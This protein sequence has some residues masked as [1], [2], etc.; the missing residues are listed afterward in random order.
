M[1]KEN[2]VC[3]VCHSYT[4][5]LFRSKVLEKYTV[6]YYKCLSCE[7]IQTEKQYWTKEAYSSA[8]IDTDTG[9][10]DRNLK[11]SKISAIIFLLFCDKKSKVLDYAGGY[12]IMTRLLRDIGLDC[13][14]AD[15]YAENIFAR[16]FEIKID[17]KFDLVTSFELFEHLENPVKEIGGIV[18]KFKPKALLF[19]T[20][21]H[22]G[23]PLKDWWY[24]APEGVLRFWLLRLE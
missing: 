19:S 3:V 2:P 4:K 11:L 1:I 12:G 24:F 10:M 8:I 22:N 13:Y 7:L 23:N 16:G 18:K 15:K 6:S 20:M 14:R 9:I 17:E 5:I 21:L